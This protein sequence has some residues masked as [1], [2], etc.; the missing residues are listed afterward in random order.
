MLIK[1]VIIY[2]FPNVFSI[3]QQIIL[4][5]KQQYLITDD[6]NKILKIL[7]DLNKMNSQI[8]KNNIY[9][10]KVIIDLVELSLKK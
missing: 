10:E 2:I 1:Y 5:F 7:I 4:Y 9:I 3:L 8:G 6:K